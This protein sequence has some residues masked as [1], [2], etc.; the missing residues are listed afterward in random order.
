MEH[1][2]W[3]KVGVECIYF[4][5]A[6]TLLASLDDHAHVEVD[7][8]VVEPIEPR[9]GVE[10]RSLDVRPESADKCDCRRHTEGS[11]DLGFHRGCDVWEAGLVSVP[12]GTPRSLALSRGERYIG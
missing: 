12:L 1:N 7:D 9:Q 3:V 5:P 6:V 11:I 8:L 10:V 2:L 4:R